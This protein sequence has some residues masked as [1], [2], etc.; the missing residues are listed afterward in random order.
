MRLKYRCSGCDERCKAIIKNATPP[1]MFCI[2]DATT[3]PKW[4]D[5]T[6]YKMS[7]RYCNHMLVEDGKYYCRTTRKPDMVNIGLVVLQEVSL[8]FACGKF[9]NSSHPF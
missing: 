6:K 1:P 2:F 3:D 4:E 7:C 5:V 8:N 9:Q